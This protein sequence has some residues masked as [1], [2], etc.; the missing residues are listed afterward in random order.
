MSEV[1]LF[2]GY[3][4]STRQSQQQQP[5]NILVACRCP[6]LVDD[7]QRNI[8]ALCFCSKLSAM[9]HIHYRIKL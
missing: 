7:H 3:K 9:N 2:D 6:L 1:G 8:L 5:P 4:S